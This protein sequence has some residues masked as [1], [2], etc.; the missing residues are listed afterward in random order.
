MLLEVN[1]S[2]IL[3]FDSERQELI[4]QEPAIGLAP[5]FIR[6][7]HIPLNSNGPVWD[8]WENGKSLTINNMAE[9]P[10]VETLG[11]GALMKERDVRATMFSALRMGGQSIGWFQVSDKVDGSDFTPEDQRVLEILASQSAIAIENARLFSTE[12][13]RA[14][15]METLVEIAQAV[16]KAVTEDPR[17]LLERIARGACEV[18]HADFAVLY[19]FI[20]A[21]PDAYDVSNVATFGT[22]HPLEPRRK[23]STDDPVHIIR[24][25]DLLVCED[26]SRELPALLQDPFLERESIRAFV[27]ILLEADGEELG[28]L[29]VN[30]RAP[31]LFEEPE[32]TAVRLIAHQASLAISKSRLFEALNQDLLQTNNDLLRKLREMEELQ[33]ISNMI[34]STLDIDKV[35][36]GILHGAMSIAGAPFANIMMMDEESGAVIAHVRRGDQMLTNRIDPRETVTIPSMAE[37]EH[38]TIV[39]DMTDPSASEIPWIAIYRQLIP[40]ARSVI[41]TPIIGG[42][43]GRRIGLLGIGSPRPAEFGSADRYLLEALA[44]HAAIAIQN[45]RSLQTVRDYQERAVEAERITAMAD[46]AGNM[47]H[48]INTTVGAIRPLIQQIE[49]KLERGGLEEDYLQD[50]LHGIRESADRTL[51]VARQIQ[52]PFL[53]APLQSIDVNESIAAAWADLK[54]PVGVDVNIEYGENLPPVKATRQ[55]DEVFRNLMKN[56]LDAMAHAGGLL[57]VRSR[58][59]YGHLV[60]VMVKDTGPGIPPEL[61]EKIFRVGT[62]T[63]PSG[64]GY[65]LWWSQMF[66]RRLGGGMALKSIEGKGCEFTVTLPS[67]SKVSA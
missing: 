17:A 55:L 44:N 50:K 21:E 42:D 37:G 29:Y 59:K 20:A 32:L 35:F 11:L 27:G 8:A 5:D 65:G 4:C 16:T 31:H 56:A 24:E 6:D 22:L 9:S 49:L 12:K 3:L 52:R 51:E 7:Y 66:L 45:A 58:Y 1:N 34:S 18:L 38:S 25:C 47:V 33:K 46:V 40:D 14:S 67:E 26:V 39:Q 30:F 62:T 19:P 43:E 53:S 2:A 41:Y 57:S 28:V 23:V 10:L 36:D 60:E 13:R 61:R 54:T 64:M 48:R 15:E 63:K